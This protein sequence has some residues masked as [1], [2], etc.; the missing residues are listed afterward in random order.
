MS[1]QS[2]PLH[3][4][5]AR[6]VTT[7]ATALVAALVTL[8]VVAAPA[9]A[10]DSVSVEINNLPSN[11]LVNV[12]T[13]FRVAMALS[14]RNGQPIPNVQLVF[15]VRLEGAPADAVHVQKSFGSDLP[16]GNAGDGTV[17]FTDTQKTTIQTKSVTQTFLL[18]FSGN[19]PSGN[20]SVTVE[21]YQDDKRLGSATKSTRV[22]GTNG[23]QAQPP[24][25][26]TPPNTNPGYVPTF[27]P[28]PTYSL[29]ALPPDNRVDIDAK[30]PSTLYWLGGLLVGLGGLLLFLTFRRQPGTA[31]APSGANDTPGGAGQ[32]GRPRRA[33]FPGQDPEQ[34]PSGPRPYPW[35]RG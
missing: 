1:T 20:A 5:V 25:K 9:R 21:A 13:Y 15:T 35:N 4:H 30:V 28:G 2:R 33:S 16:R 7:A 19:A 10:A 14:D 26:T 31:V 22:R 27:E 11:V 8:L 17:R 24:T 3:R 6:R 29:A 32:P 18:L 23:Q 34:P 12:P